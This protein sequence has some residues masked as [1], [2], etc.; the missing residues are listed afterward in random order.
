MI[1]DK[2]D[3]TGNW[4]DPS[5]T[6]MFVYSM[7]KGIES[8]LLEKSEYAPVV[9]K[10]YTSLLTFARINEQGLVD[11][12]GG[13]DGITIKKD[14]ETY[15]NVPRVINAKEAV[16]GFLWATALMGKHKL[17]KLRSKQSAL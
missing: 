12:H 11:I 3:R 1:V 4:I 10:G 16:G 15:I 5:G 9:A 2:G 6:A 8:G 13:G 17:E 14:F 7:Q